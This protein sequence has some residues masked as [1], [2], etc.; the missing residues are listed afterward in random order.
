[1]DPSSD[2]R[3]GEPHRRAFLAYAVTA[4]GAATVARLLDFDPRPADDEDVIVIRAEKGDADQAGVIQVA[5]D[6]GRPVKITGGRVL[7]RRS[8]QIRK[9]GTKLSLSPST[10]LI[11]DH[12]DPVVI[13]EQANSFELEGNAGYIDLQKR[14]HTAIAVGS[15]SSNSPIIGLTI[16]NIRIGNNP[17]MAPLHSAIELRRVRNARLNTVHIYNYGSAQ[18]TEQLRNEKG[19]PNG[20]VYGIGVFFSDQV[21]IEK[22]VVER[23]CVGVLVQESS[24]VRIDRTLV[25][26][27]FDNGIYILSGSIGI[28][29]TESEI[30]SCEEGIVLL[31]DFTR[32]SGCRIHGC[33][34]K[35]ITLRSTAFSTILGCTI[36]DNRVGIGD[37]RRDTSQQT[38]CVIA[39]NIHSGNGE[40]IAL[41]GAENVTIVGNIFAPSPTGEEPFLRLRGAL[42]TKIT[43]NTF[44]SKTGNNGVL[45]EAASRDVLIAS[46]T[47]RRSRKAIV[48]RKVNT[49]RPGRTRIGENTFV[50]VETKVSGIEDATETTFDDW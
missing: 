45:I 31:S 33:F 40:A 28:D 29:V 41:E 17:T 25:S 8:L 2:A 49:Q 46:N 1:M 19:Q 13:C 48:L 21:T 47:F 7:L 32:I 22:S 9:N 44:A 16:S 14:S 50:D 43:S 42:S 5:L 6:S 12:S 37:D 10:H 36:S 11:A 23:G 38:S 15:D 26:G 34:N 18:D 4:L 30:S 27:M 39:N 20:Q 3:P 24:A 35:G